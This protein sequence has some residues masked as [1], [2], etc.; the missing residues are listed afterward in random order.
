MPNKTARLIPYLTFDGNCEEALHFY[1]DIL[2]GNL[3]V[4]TRYN[5]PAMNAP[6]HY[7]DKI[8][9]ARLEV[10]EF[11]AIYAS[12][13]WPGK[14]TRKNSGDV[15]F[16]IIYKDTIE[17]AQKVYDKLA[18]GGKASMPF[19]KQFWGDYHGNL[20]DRYGIHWNIN[21]ELPR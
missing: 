20:V 16:S 5:N 8:L 1:Q 11:F 17:E 13:T 6:E 14:P 10:N 18:E 4:V 7:K 21:F 3:T 12:D 2:G 9:H 15:S 19:A